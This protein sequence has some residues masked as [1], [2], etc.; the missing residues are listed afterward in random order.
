MAIRIKPELGDTYSILLSIIK[1]G[2]EGQRV[3]FLVPASQGDNYI[4]RIR[5]K[6]TR[7]RKEMIAKNRRQKRFKLRATK[8]Q[9]TE[10]GI[11]YDALVFWLERGINHTI[12]EDL[13][14]LLSNG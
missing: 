13:E 8:H 4:A 9:H 10:G 7:T 11:R 6:L 3:M 2:L 12:A 5:T 1:H 14:D